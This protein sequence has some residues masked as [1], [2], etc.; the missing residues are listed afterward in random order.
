MNSGGPI[1][2]SGRGSVRC[3]ARGRGI[4][5]DALAGGL[6]RWRNCTRLLFLVQPWAV[7]YTNRAFSTLLGRLFRG[8]LEAVSIGLCLAPTAAD[9][10]ADAHTPRAAATRPAVMAWMGTRAS[11]SGLRISRPC[12]RS[13]AARAGRTR[14]V[15]SAPACVRRPPKQPPVPPAVGPRGAAGRAKMLIFLTI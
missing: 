6:E 8:G 13:R 4:R 12:S 11:P 3:N 7:K 9:T 14:K 15:T 1:S 5:A 10:P 2:A